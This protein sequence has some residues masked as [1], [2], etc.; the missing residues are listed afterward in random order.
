MKTEPK[1]GNPVIVRLFDARTIQGTVCLGGIMQTVSG[2]KIRVRSGH[3]VYLVNSEQIISPCDAVYLVNR[4]K[5]GAA[6]NV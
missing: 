4:T 5:S 3:A 2:T 6:K 1:P